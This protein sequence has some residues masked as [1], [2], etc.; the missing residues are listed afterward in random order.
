MRPHRL[1]PHPDPDMP[2]CPFEKDSLIWLANVIRMSRLFAAALA[3]YLMPQPRQSNWLNWASDWSVLSRRSWLY[4]A[5]IEPNLALCR[6]AGYCYPP[7]LEL[8]G[9]T[10]SS[11][12]RKSPDE[13]VV[14]TWSLS[15]SA[16]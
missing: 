8:R 4:E 11:A 13:P 2:R 16:G 14:V 10:I 1:L 6:Q 7:V 9:T 12:V 15:N 5:R 3:R